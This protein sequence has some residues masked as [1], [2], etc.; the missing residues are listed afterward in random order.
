[1]SEIS[2]L[3]WIS[4]APVPANVFRAAEHRWHVR[5]GQSAG[6][7]AASLAEAKLAVLHP[8][9]HCDSP[10]A[11]AELVAEVEASHAVAVFMLP[12]GA[13]AAR[14]MLTARGGSILC[15]V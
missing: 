14:D 1:M 2:T 12:D 7:R 10:L 11:L 3:L 5:D 15:G 8:R 6:N 13:T 9:E 4:D